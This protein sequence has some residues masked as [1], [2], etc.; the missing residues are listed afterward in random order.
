[1]SYMKNLIENNK[2][3]DFYK[4]ER[5]Q[6]S[7]SR[8]DPRKDIHEGHLAVNI[9]NYHLRITNQYLFYNNI[10]TMNS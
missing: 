5:I 8:I 3:L 6:Y 4:H 10:L 2:E 1:M 9:K 7:W